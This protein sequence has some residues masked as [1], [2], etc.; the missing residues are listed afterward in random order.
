MLNL[1]AEIYKTF[2]TSLGEE[3][4][5]FY[6]DVVEQG[7]SKKEMIEKYNI[8]N[9]TYT[10]MYEIVD[11]KIKTFLINNGYHNPNNN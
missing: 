4:L 9:A 8:N 10:L 3:L 1:K 5:D 7:Y 11:K 6:F 2:E